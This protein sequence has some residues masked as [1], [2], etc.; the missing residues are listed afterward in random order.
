VH[1]SNRFARRQLEDLAAE[2]GHGRIRDG[3]L[4]GSLEQWFE[5]ASPVWAAPT[6]AHTR[7]II[8]CHLKPDL[9]HLYV[10]KLKTEDIDGPGRRRSRGP[11]LPGSLSFRFDG[12]RPSDV[13]PRVLGVSRWAQRRAAVPRRFVVLVALAISLFV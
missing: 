8:D 1:G 7:S 6:V 4:S 13:R 9:G 10:A 11:R 3:T 2:A 5:A 12:R